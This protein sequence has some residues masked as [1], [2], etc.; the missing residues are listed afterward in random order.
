MSKCLHTLNNKLQKCPLLP[1]HT[2]NSANA[3]PTL[4]QDCK[5]TDRCEFKHLTKEFWFLTVKVT[6]QGDR[7]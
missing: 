4:I 6:G 7:V 2:R 5:D 1:I 3:V